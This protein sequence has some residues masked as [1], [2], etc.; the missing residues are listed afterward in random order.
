MLVHVHLWPENNKTCWQYSVSTLNWG[1]RR[2]FWQLRTPQLAVGSTQSLAN[3]FVLLC[4]PLE[5]QSNPE[6]LIC[7]SACSLQFNAILYNTIPLNS[8][9]FTPL[10]GY[11]CWACGCRWISS[12]W[13]WH[14]IGRSSPR[15]Q[16]IGRSSP[17]WQLIGCS[18]IVECIFRYFHSLLYILFMRGR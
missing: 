12:M 6:I 11:M 14:L 13:R 17:R 3:L 10:T 2:K 8:K 15:W 4:L 1:E 7:T 9:Y 5:Y 16:L 18:C